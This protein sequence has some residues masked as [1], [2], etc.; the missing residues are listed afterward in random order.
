MSKKCEYLILL[1]I[2]LLIPTSLFS[3]TEDSS[4]CDLIFIQVPYSDSYDFD[5][6]DDVVVSVSYS[7]KFEVNILVI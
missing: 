3:E 7:D 2:N 4:S 5:I 1:L 6:S